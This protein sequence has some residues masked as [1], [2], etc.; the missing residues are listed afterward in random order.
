LDSY[1]A[2][3]PAGGS[4]LVREVTQLRTLAK[5]L[6]SERNIQ[7]SEQQCTLQVLG[8]VDDILQLDEEARGA[9]VCRWSGPS[10]P[11]GS[12]GRSRKRKRTKGRATAMG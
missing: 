6:L 12:S 9:G 11:R 7:R 2:D 10:R 5:K 1:T 8:Y 3:L 4:A